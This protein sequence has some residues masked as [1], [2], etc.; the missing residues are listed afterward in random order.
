MY[1]AI[2]K[3]ARSHSSLN[4]AQQ[5]DDKNLP[6]PLTLKQKNKNGRKSHYIENIK[7]ECRAHK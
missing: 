2:V 1:K 5:N 3:A 7:T 6:H 4:L